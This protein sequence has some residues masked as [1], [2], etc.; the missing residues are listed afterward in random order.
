MQVPCQP[1]TY[2][3]HWGNQFLNKPKRIQKCTLGTRFCTV[4]LSNFSNLEPAYTK[5]YK[6]NCVSIRGSAHFLHPDMLHA[7][8]CI[9]YIVYNI[10]HAAHDIS[11]NHIHCLN[12]VQILS[13][14]QHLNSIQHLNPVHSLNSIQKINAI[15]YWSNIYWISGYMHS[16]D[17]RV[18]SSVGM[19]LSDDLS[20]WSSRIILS[21]ALVDHPCRSSQSDHLNNFGRLGWSEIVTSRIVT[22]RITTDPSFQRCEL[23]LS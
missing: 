15:L 18:G 9:R 19:I 4:F 1:V 2:W 3:N 23:S 13:V 6:C 12:R 10:L 21:Y 7:I 17:H 5:T 16:S 14:I 22:S 20:G 8:Y 11:L